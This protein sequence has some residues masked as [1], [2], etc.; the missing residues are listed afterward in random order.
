MP[1]THHGSVREKTGE[2]F[3]TSSAVASSSV[4]VSSGKVRNVLITGYTDRRSHLSRGRG[5][6]PPVGRYIHLDVNRS[7]Q[8]RPLSSA[9]VSVLAPHNPNAPPSS[10]MGKLRTESFEVDPEAVLKALVTTPSPV[11]ARLIGVSDNDWQAEHKSI[12]ES[13]AGATTKDER[14]PIKLRIPALV[15]ARFKGKSRS[16]D[17][18]VERQVIG[19]DFDSIPGATWEDVVGKV[20]ELL[21]GRFVALHTTATERGDDGTWRVRAYEVL[22]R[23]ATPA[24]WDTHVKSHMRALG[25]SDANALDVARLLFMPIETRGYRSAVIEGPRTKL[26]DIL[27]LQP[28]SVPS[29]ARTGIVYTPTGNTTGPAAALLASAWPEKGKRNNAVMVLAGAL[30]H[31]GWTEPETLAFVQ[32]VY[33]HVDPNVDKDELESTVRNTYRAKDG[34]K[35]ISGWTTLNTLMPQAVVTAARGLLDVH[36]E[37]RATFEA[38]FGEQPAA[39]PPAVLRPGM[40]VKERLAVQRGGPAVATPITPDDNEVIPPPK[41]LPSFPVE[42]LPKA[43]R[44]FVVAEAEATQT[45]VDMAAM[46]CLG[47]CSA[48]I[49]G[50]VMITL[51]QWDEPLNLFVVV[52]APPGKKKSGVLSSALQPLHDAEEARIVE[53]APLIAK[54]KTARDLLTDQIKQSKSALS[55]LKPEEMDQE[56]VANQTGATPRGGIALKRQI[57]EMEAR[58]RLMD[59]PSE[60]RLVADDVTMEGLAVL[61]SRNGGRMCIAS[62]EGTIFGIAAG[63]YSGQPSFDVLLKGHAGDSVTVDRKSKDHEPIRIRKACVTAVLAVQPSIIEKLNSTDEM[64]GQGLLARF[65]YSIAGERPGEWDPDPSRVPEAIRAAY[66]DTIRKLDAV[67][68]PQETALLGRQVNGELDIDQLLAAS[69]ASGGA[70]PTIALGPEAAALFRAFR[71]EHHARMSGDLASMPE[72]ADKWPGAVARIAGVLHCIEHGAT[73]EIS[74]GAI[75]AAIEIGHYLLAHARAAFGLASASSTEQD[76]ESLVAWVKRSEKGAFSLRDVARGGPKALREKKRREAALEFLFE[77]GAITREGALLRL[78]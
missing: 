48:A 31:Q 27:A 69:K 66:H 30:S 33:R 63:R 11:V 38:E 34:G 9:F 72:W 59:V 3:A 58:L 65:L 13:L 21:P 51:G 16:K 74:E 42:V 2:S 77:Q 46:L 56:W 49:A 52:V 61:L 8:V 60:P 47:C 54:L 36:A 6:N 62:A 44:D 14:K 73:G 24:Q 53:A 17:E 22:D 78:V 45:P 26:D 15:P 23:G 25:E 5:T 43:L 40:S 68:T 39:P 55:K 67:Q 28:D 32:D 75:K 19:H 35:N 12:V 7:P 71:I 20:R 1:T 50:K 64:K 76:A 41:P 18:C 57:A 10:H 29:P 70:V 4:C 37:L